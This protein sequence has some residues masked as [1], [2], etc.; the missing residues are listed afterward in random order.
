MRCGCRCVHGWGAGC[1]EDH[2]L[3]HLT[4]LGPA[5]GVHGATALSPPYPNGGGP[6]EV[7]EAS[8]VTAS[9]DP[10]GL[11]MGETLGEEMGKEKPDPMAKGELV[12][13]ALT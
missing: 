11:V 3:I 6:F 8:G 1:Q 12:W 10:D 4:G 5:L 9:P 2:L 13:S 7:F